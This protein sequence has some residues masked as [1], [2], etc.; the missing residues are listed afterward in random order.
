MT[1]LENR[2]DLALFSR[3]WN[4]RASILASHKLCKLEIGT[5]FCRP[6]HPL[7]DQPEI[8]FGTAKKTNAG[9]CR[10][11]MANSGSL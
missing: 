10:R 2:I 1:L 4:R 7:A 3:R 9:Y 6:G 8:R 11:A 5:G